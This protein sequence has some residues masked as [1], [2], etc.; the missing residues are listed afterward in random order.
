M[1]TVLAGG[2]G[3]AKFLQGLVKIVDPSDVTIIVNTG[4]D[5]E[6]HGL[7]ISPDIDT[8]IYTLSGL[9]DETR[10][11]GIKDD[12]F[13]GLSRLGHLGHETWFRLGDRDMAMHIHRTQ[14]MKSGRS[15]SEVTAQVS[16]AL[17][18]ECRILPMTNCRV[19]TRIITEEEVLGFQ[20]YLVKRSATD[21]V[22]SIEFKGI[23]EALP[24]KGVLDAINKSERIILAPSNPLIS[25]GP[26][27][28]VK[29]IRK[30]LKACKAPKIA[31]SPIIGGAALK[32]PAAD[33]MRDLGMEV[34]A[35]QVAR[36][37]SDFLD[38]FI[39]DQ[40]DA[41]LLGN[42]QELG[43]KAV[44]TNTVMTGLAEKVLLAGTT[45]D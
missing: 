24:T 25:I 7:Y 26:I 27:L 42:V 5:V 6:L 2:V 22:K 4:D 14:L 30:A 17:D 44:A 9:A 20:E 41:E 38:A 36:L 15:L 23:E 18:I 43:I 31:T 28:A 37:Y 34:S 35:Y 39:L 19:E 3:A 40:I 13:Y 21:R 29:G 16:Q 32:G 12:T 11:W 33:M 10:G 1:I 8:I 45:L